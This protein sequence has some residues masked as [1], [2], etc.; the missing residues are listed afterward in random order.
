MTNFTK[1]Q[2]RKIAGFTLVEMLVAVFVFSIVMTIATG[3]I[4]TIVSA[5][6]TSQALKSVL[7][8]LNSALDD[9]SGAMRYGSYYD[10]EAASSGASDKSSSL[11]GTPAC[12]TDGSTVISFINKDGVL[13]TYQFVSE[14]IQVR[15]GGSG[16]SFV[17]LTAPEVHIKDL[18]FKVTGTKTSDSLVQPQV[19]ITLSGW[20]SSGTNKSTFNIE[21]M[22]TQRNPACKQLMIDAGVCTNNP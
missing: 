4:F 15:V 13:V 1:N 8:N 20:A 9:M 22:I 2:K 6:K 11:A 17:D 21:T 5:N 16:S 19:V 10:C 14:K 7:D 3:A 18:K 12:S